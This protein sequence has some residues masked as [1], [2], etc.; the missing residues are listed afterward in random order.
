MRVKLGFQTL[1]RFLTPLLLIWRQQT[2]WSLRVI[3]F[4]CFNW[5][6]GGYTSRPA[7][8][9]HGYSFYSGGLR[10]STI[11]TCL[12]WASWC[13]SVLP[14]ASVAPSCQKLTRERPSEPELMSP[15]SVQTRMSFLTSAGSDPNI[16][17]WYY[18]YLSLCLRI[19]LQTSSH[20]HKTQAEPVIYLS[21]LKNWALP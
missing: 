16:D 6:D 17:K 10:R 3:L 5:R 1:Q 20:P 14:T 13:Y 7:S 8:I 15:F 2:S 12:W 19:Y 4:V 11:L 21:L 9:S 18:E